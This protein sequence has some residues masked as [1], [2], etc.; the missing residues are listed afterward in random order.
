MYKR[1]IYSF[2]DWVGDVGGLLDGLKIFGGFIMSAYTTLVGNPLS[3]FLAK[4]LFKKGTD[5]E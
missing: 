1:S 5:K 2:F 3:A 4:K